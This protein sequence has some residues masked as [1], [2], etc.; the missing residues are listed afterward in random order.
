MVWWL[1]DGFLLFSFTTL[2][3]LICDINSRVFTHEL[4]KTNTFKH[5]ALPPDTDALAYIFTSMSDAV[6]QFT[7]AASS[8]ALW[9]LG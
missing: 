6:S 2:L 9:R 3:V 4:M 7:I 5:V 1:S 8:D